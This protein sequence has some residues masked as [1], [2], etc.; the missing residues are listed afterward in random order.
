MGY[1][2]P[3]TDKD[4]MFFS[5]VISEKCTQL[6][7]DLI[8]S[9][10]GKISGGMGQFQITNISKLTYSMH[11]NFY[12]PMPWLVTFSSDGFLTIRDYSDLPYDVE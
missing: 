11:A 7:F 12:S 10:W 9:I 8:L 5:S 4:I 2:K 6:T 1:F 3:K